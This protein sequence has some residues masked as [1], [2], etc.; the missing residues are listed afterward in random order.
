MNI[1]VKHDSAVPVYMQIRNQ[2]RDIIVSGILPPGYLLP[3][4]R[5]LARCLSVNRSTVVRAYEELKADALVAA[6]PG[7]RAMVLAGGEGAGPE[8]NGVKAISWERYFNPAIVKADGDVPVKRK[9]AASG[10][11]RISFALGVPAPELFPEAPLRSIKEKA[12]QDEGILQLLQASNEGYSPLK[13]TI[14]DLMLMRG[15]S[16]SPGDILLLS[17]SRQG[18]YLASMALLE[19]GDAVIVE[20]PSYFKAIEI[21]NLIGVRL[22]GVP[23]DSEGIRTDVLEQLLAKYRPKLIYT[24]PTFHNP[25]GVVMSMGR[26][27]ALLE[28]AYRYGVPIVE[29]DPYAELR[30]EGEGLPALK[31]LDRYG[32][33][34]YIGTMSYILSPGL[35]IGWVI[36]P[37]AVLGSLDAVKRVAD[38]K[39]NVLMEY[40]IDQFVRNDLYSDYMN[41]IRKQYAGRRDTLT[42]AIRNS[43][44]HRIGFRNP[45]GGYFV[46]CT[47]P[48]EIA[49]Q[50]LISNAAKRNVDFAPGSLFYC[51]RQGQNHFRLGFTGLRPELIEEG[52]RRLSQAVNDTMSKE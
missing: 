48:D 50:Q 36:A 43:L 45:E 1:I 30:Y 33:V 11:E 2:I 51:K 5:K 39:N 44:A 8:R 35:K 13:E 31:A 34:I 26:R 32:F 14:S 52:I 18:I 25:T 17:G 38:I 4:E 29:D 21:F 42:S 7:K 47:L 40:V 37:Q 46:W 49:Q 15:I 10:S 20:E 12:L 9:I 3:S 6:S 23:L 16:A 24:M 41:L 19:K 28:L 27:Q 22:L